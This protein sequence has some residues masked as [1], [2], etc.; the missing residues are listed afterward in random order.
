MYQNAFAAGA[1]PSTSLGEPTALPQ[2]L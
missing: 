1:P 2:A